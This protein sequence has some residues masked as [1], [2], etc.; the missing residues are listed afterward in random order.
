MKL[1]V[2]GNRNNIEEVVKTKP[3]YL[4][5]IFWEP[6]DRYFSDELPKIP[7]NIKKVGVFVDAGLEEVLEKLAKYRL[8][9]LQLHGTESAAYCAALRKLLRSDEGPDAK[10][11]EIIK[12]FTIKDRFNFE[13]LEAY[14][15][16]CDYFLFDTKG[17]LPGGN[18]YAFDWKVLEK[19]PSKKPFFLSG[20]I[21]LA[22]KEDV[23]EF[24]KTD[25]AAYCQVLD[26]NSRFEIAPGLKDVEQLSEFGGFVDE[27]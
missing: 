24:L 6:S 15:S 17:E 9:A 20:G 5:F 11:V 14:E 2:C 13:V 8:D 1:K 7:Q 18:G 10:A 22:Q 25:V 19:Y 23:A 4:G 26:V 12:V 3:D 27:L 21:G 16:V